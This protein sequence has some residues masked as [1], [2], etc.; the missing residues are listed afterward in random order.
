MQLGVYEEIIMK[1][2]FNNERLDRWRGVLYAIPQDMD[3]YR[4]KS[5]QCNNYLRKIAF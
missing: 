3:N 2:A 4:L 1:N 5:S